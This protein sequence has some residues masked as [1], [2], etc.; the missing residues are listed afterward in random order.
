MQAGW[1]KYSQHARTLVNK[2][3]SLKLRLKL[4]DAVVSPCVLFGLGTLPLYE[5]ALLKLEASQ[6]KM[7]RRIVGWSRSPD[8]PWASTMRRMNEKLDD[9]SRIWPIQGWRERI[10]DARRKQCERIQQMPV[11]N[12]TRVAAEWDPLLMQD[13]SSS[14]VFSR[15]VGRPRRRWNDNV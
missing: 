5:D 11:H 9:A 7:L 6:R 15:P 8:E 3:V 10:L 13:P 1:A 4:F 12:L 14:H 2:K